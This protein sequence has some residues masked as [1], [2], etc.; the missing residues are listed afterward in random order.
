MMLGMSR[1]MVT[2]MQFN[3]QKQDYDKSLADLTEGTE[4]Y[5]RALHACHERG[6]KR[7]ADVAR[8]HRGIYVKAAQ[9]IA[10]LRGGTGDRG[11]PR[12][13]SEALKVFTDHAPHK[14]IAEV[15]ESLR[16]CMSLGNWPAGPLGDASD[17][18]WI[19]SEPIAAASLAQVH[20]AELQDGT[21]VAV[22]VQYPDLRKEMAADFSVFKTM[23]EQIKQM[24]QGYDLMWIVEDFEKNLTRELD[25]RIE[26]TEGEATAKQ[27]A[28]LSPQV[29]VPRVYRGL[30]SERVLVMEYCEDLAKLTDP[31]GLRAVGLEPEECAALVCT[32]FAEMIFVHGRV[33]A[34]PH[35]GN[36]YVRPVEMGGRKRAQL[37]LLDHGLYFDLC[38][39]DVRLNFCKYWQACCAKDS[40]TMAAIGQR[41]AGA[42]KRFLPLILSPWFIF[43]GSGVSL[44]EVVSAAKGELPDTIG[45]RDVADFVVATRE[46]GANVISLLH[47]LG[48]TRG[49]LEALSYREDRRLAAMLRFAIAGD[50]L[51]PHTPPRAL[52]RRESAWVI[53]RVG[54]LRCHIAVLQPLAGPLLRFAHTEKAPPLW[55]LASGPALVAAVGAAL[56]FRWQRPVA[57]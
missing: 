19:E 28:H 48:Y 33:H 50:A 57:V 12:Q 36:I 34:D 37:V 5:N 47:S 17:L 7:C 21:K 40:I 23:G 56:I 14:P 53:W 46:G 15:A 26:A 30:S 55:L 42:L 11:V 6:A 52:S 25:F 24:S 31:A 51:K 3:E 41:F 29:Y 45:L 4:D 27:L 49:L 18:K 54:I 16:A 20:R 39:N 35:A 43:G 10:S 38:E 1:S 22:K 44:R 13:Y 8:M 2:M 32:T 9:F